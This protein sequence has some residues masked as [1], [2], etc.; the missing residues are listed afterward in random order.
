MTHNAWFGGGRIKG[1]RFSVNVSRQQRL[2]TGYIRTIARPAKCG[3]NVNRRFHVVAQD[4]PVRPL[5]VVPIEV[6]PLVELVRQPVEVGEQVKRRGAGILPAIFASWDSCVWIWPT[7]ARLLCCV[8]LRISL[9][10]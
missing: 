7:V 9:F 5:P 1:T 10:R 2:R 6:D 8:Q 4:Q 3:E